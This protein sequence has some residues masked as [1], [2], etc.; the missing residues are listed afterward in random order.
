LEN[1][2]F[3]GNIIRYL[4]NDLQGSLKNYQIK[5][6]NYLDKSDYSCKIDDEET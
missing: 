4:L 1:G 2:N 3:T 5:L 6:T